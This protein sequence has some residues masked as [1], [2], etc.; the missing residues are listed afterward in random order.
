MRTRFQKVLGNDESKARLSE[1]ILSS[2]LP[3]ALMITGPEGSGKHT[4][5]KEIAAAMNCENRDNQDFVLPCGVCNRCKRIYSG[6]FPDISYLKR[7]ASRATIGVEDVRDFRDDMFLSSTESVYKFYIIEESDVM[8]REAQNALLKV[9]EEPPLN[10]HIIL[11]CREADKILTT[12]KS[13]AQL[14]QTE[15]FTNE[16]LRSFVLKLSENARMLEQTD[17]KKLTGILL[18]TG[19]VIGEALVLLDDA[20]IADTEDERAAV[21]SFIEAIA[22][23]VPFLTLQAAANALPKDRDALRKAMEIIRNA[24][25]DM[26]SLKISDEISPIFFLSKEDMEELSTGISKMRLISVYDIITNAIS[27]LDKNVNISILL[28]DIAVKIKET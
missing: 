8:T 17:S 2:S 22:K 10:V 18:A 27:D 12:V 16:K 7:Q 28:T 14:I 21:R 5:A 4:I 24:L 3:H 25:R 26:I 20:H 1:L 15:I 13:R 11:L 19:G 6:N 23:K 9:L